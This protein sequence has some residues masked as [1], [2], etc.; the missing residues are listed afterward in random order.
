MIIES[1]EVFESLFSLGKSNGFGKSNSGF[2][3]FGTTVLDVLSG[4]GLLLIIFV[5]AS[6]VL[7]TYTELNWELFIF[8]FVSSKLTEEKILSSFQ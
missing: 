4:V 7:F 2:N 5:G 1:F 3:G 6:T 8:L